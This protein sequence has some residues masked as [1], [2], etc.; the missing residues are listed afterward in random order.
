[1]KTLIIYDSVFGNT[2]KIARAIGDAIADEV[3]VL[4]AS[5]VNSSQFKT[6]DLLIVGSPTQGGRPTRAIQDMLNKVH[7]SDFK[8]ANMAAFDTRLSMRLVG[9]FGYAAEKI[10]DSL[11]KDGWNIVVSPEGFFVKGKTGPLKKGELERAAGW[12]K[13]IAERA[14]GRTTTE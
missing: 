7:V 11:K 14:K 10:A 8:G 13:E 6:V 4:H 9:I 3:K 2:E 12:A 5:E 1:M